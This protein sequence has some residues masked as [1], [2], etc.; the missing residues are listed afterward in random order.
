MVEF[1][2]T[3]DTTKKPLLEDIRLSDIS[4]TDS[5]KQRKNNNIVDF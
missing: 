2:K 5:S 4:D 1:K 3:S